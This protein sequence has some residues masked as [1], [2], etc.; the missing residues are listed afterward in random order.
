MDE[1][2]LYE[3][4]LLRKDLDSLAASIRN[5]DESVLRDFDTNHIVPELLG[6]RC[7]IIGRRSAVVDL[8]QRHTI[9]SPTAL[10]RSSVR[11]VYNDAP[12]LIAIGDIHF[13][14]WV[15]HE[16][17]GGRTKDAGVLI[18]GW[19]VWRMADLQKLFSVGRQFEHL[20]I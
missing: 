6:G 4:S 2:F 14:R 15:I 10:E 17:L 8:A 13:M 18:I 12:V 7:G 19:R 11:I 16:D 5:I 9:G 1:K 20:T 3:L